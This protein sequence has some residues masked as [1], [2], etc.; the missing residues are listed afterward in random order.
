MFEVGFDSPRS[1]HKK[2]DIYHNV[3]VRG[4]RSVRVVL[5]RKSRT[6]SGSFAAEP[7]QAVLAASLDV[8]A[9]SQAALAASQAALATSQAASQGPLAASQAALAAAHAALAASQTYLA[10]S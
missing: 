2:V 7:Q 6:A 8:L 10:A 4:P 9:A 1:G 3:S 5:E